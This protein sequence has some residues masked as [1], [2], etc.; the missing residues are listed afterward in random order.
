MR[1]IITLAVGLLLFLLQSTI[2]EFAPVHLVTPSL[3]LLVVLYVGMAS[4]KW[5]AASAVLVGFCLG[6]LFDLVSGAPRGVHAF[7]FI[8]IAL[9]ARSLALRLAVRGVVLKAA[10]AFIASLLT[11]G[12]IV[13]VRAQ[14]SPESGYGG[15]RHAPL[16]AL[17]T[18]LI[19]PPVLWLLARLD[20]RLDPALLRV[21]LARRRARVLDS[22][23][24]PR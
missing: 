9:V 23:I 16:E 7:V 4:M 5:S 14:I 10:T 18:A 17:L 1:S 22:G 21:G 6:Y 12:L 3:G 8:V 2:M 19:A 11:A 15:L 20:G 13:L 24:P